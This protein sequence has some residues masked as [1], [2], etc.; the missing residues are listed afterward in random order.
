MA[1]I[2][3]KEAVKAAKEALL[4]LYEDDPPAAMALEEIEK[5]EEDGRELWAVTLGFYRNKNV[6]VKAANSIGAI[7]NPVSQIEHRVYKTLFIDAVSGEFVKM[8]IRQVQ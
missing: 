7:Y 6:A 3:V 1:A 4:D 5:T 8:D 2:N